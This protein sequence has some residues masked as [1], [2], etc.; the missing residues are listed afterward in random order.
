MLRQCAS[1][2]IWGAVDASACFAYANESCALPGVTCLDGSSCVS[3]TC[4]PPAGYEMMWDAKGYFTGRK[5]GKYRLAF[6]EYVGW[7]ASVAEVRFMY[8][9]HSP[10]QCFTYQNDSH[11]PMFHI[12]YYFTT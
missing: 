1:G 3:G 10:T 11:N 8:A 6:P 7:N 5:F 12:S 9:M 2:G 4:Q